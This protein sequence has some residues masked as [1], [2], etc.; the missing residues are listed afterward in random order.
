MENINDTQLNRPA[1]GFNLGA[2]TL[3]LFWSIANQCFKK[4][5]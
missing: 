2:A 5:V 3:G 1:K 4:M